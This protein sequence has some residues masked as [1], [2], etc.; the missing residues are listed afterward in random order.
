[1]E[2]L[3]QSKMLVW[4]DKYNLVKKIDEQH[5]F[6]FEIINDLI[7]EISST[8]KEESVKAIIGKILEYKK[9]HFAT[10]EKYFEEFNFE[11]AAEHKEE[12]RLFG[13]EVEKISAAHAGDY[14]GLAFALV[15]FLENWLI[16]HLMSTDQK[17]KQCF[18][19]HGLE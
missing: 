3:L 4:D 7:R 6:L 1:M 11:G 12:H 17:Y 18:I 14:I 8:P 13:E 19:D 16:T 10:E 15:D 5:K 2:N 9:V